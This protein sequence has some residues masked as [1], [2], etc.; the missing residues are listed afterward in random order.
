LRKWLTIFNDSISA[1]DPSP[2]AAPRRAGFSPGFYL[3]HFPKLPKLDL[4]VEAPLSDTVSTNGAGL[5]IYWDNYYHDLYTNRHFL[6]GDWVGRD[7]AGTQAWSRYWLTVKNSI[8]L[9]YRHLKVDNK[10]IPNGGTVND[11]SV[12]AD[13][14][15]RPAV[16]ASTIVQYEQWRF[17]LLAAGLQK[18]VTASL[19][20][21]YWPQTQKH[22]R[23]G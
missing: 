20:I 12:R 3:T 10:F 16:G 2:L 6:M 11:A 13:Y 9:S 8:Q 22:W 19:Q 1:D 23:A 18:N 17:P 4:R 7:G 14:W 21:T 15:I 5:Y